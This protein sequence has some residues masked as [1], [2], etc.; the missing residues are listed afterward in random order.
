MMKTSNLFRFFARKLSLPFAVTFAGVVPTGLNSLAKFAT[1]APLLDLSHYSTSAAGVQDGDFVI[2]PPYSDAPELQKRAGVPEGKV[3]HF[4]MESVDSKI[5]PGISK[6]APGEVVHYHRAVTVYVPSQYRTGDAAPFMVCQ[7][8]FHWPEMTA[9]L[10]NMIADRKLPVMLGIFIDSGGGDAQGSER[11]LE[12]DTVSGKYAEFIESEVLPTISKLYGVK[13]SK[14]PNGRLTVGG[15]SGGAEAFSMAWFHP[16]LYRRVLSYSG[17]FV[18]Q[19]SP[20]NP[21]SPHGAWEYH[22]R[23]IPQTKRKPLRIWLEV[24]E[25]DLRYNDPESTYHNWPLADVRMAAALKA[26]HYSYQFVFAK[27]AVHVDGKVVRQTLPEAL[28]YVWKGYPI[29]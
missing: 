4:T 22:A 18:N 21:A 24:G 6:V 2:S 26:K 1:Q 10:D 9:I 12:Y 5:Y 28:L 23:L 25:H 19:Q 13:F 17:T 29:R 11:G 15:S 20:M 3:Y 8:S 16:D 27:D 7:D 14:D